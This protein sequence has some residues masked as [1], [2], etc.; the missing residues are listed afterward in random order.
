MAR[1]DE[2]L[3]MIEFEKC[4]GLI[5]AVVQE[6]VTKNVL[7]VGYMNKESL[8]K[9]IET[10]LVTYYSRSKD[11]VWTKGEESG[12]YQKVDEILV[13]CDK[14]SLLITVDQV[15]GAACH[16]GYDSCFYRKIDDGK[17]IMLEDKERMFDPAKVYNK[18]IKE[19][20]CDKE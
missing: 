14:D 19:D 5:P 6:K 2:L 20:S 10:G 1:L 4:K 9:T 15:G 3:K 18:E 16:K 13:D 12:N 8:T 7:M 11:K 17:I